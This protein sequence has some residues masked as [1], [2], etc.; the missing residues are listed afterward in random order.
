MDS[1]TRSLLAGH[2]EALAW[3]ATQR[4]EK[5]VVACIGFHRVMR[6]ARVV[7]G[8][9]AVCD[10]Y[11]PVLLGISE[12]GSYHC[13]ADGEV[14]GVSCPAI[15]PLL[16]SLAVAVPDQLAATLELQAVLLW[17]IV[18]ALQPAILHAHDIMGLRT[19][20]LLKRW[21]EAEGRQVP[22]VYDSHE[23]V[24]GLAPSRRSRTMGELQD[25]CIHAADALI[26]VGQSILTSIRSDYGFEKPG[27]IVF[28]CPPKASN[29]PAEE[30][31]L[32]SRLGLTPDTPLGVWT[33]SVTHARGPQAF[34][35]SLQR[36]TSVHLAFLTP[37]FTPFFGD[38]LDLARR[39]GCEERIHTVPLVHYSVVPNAIKGADF[40]GIGFIPNIANHEYAM[41][42]KFFEYLQAEIP[43][44]VTNVL[45]MGSFVARHGVGEVYEAD[46]AVSCAVA[47]QRVLDNGIERYAKRLRALVGTY[48]WEYQASQIEEIYSAVRTSET[49]AVGDGVEEGLYFDWVA[50][51]AWR[52][53]LEQS[54]K[55]EN[56]SEVH[57]DEALSAA[58]LWKAGEPAIMLVENPR[59]VVG[60]I[61]E[62]A[63]FHERGGVEGVK[64]TIDN[65][66][67]ACAE[68]AL[69][70][71][72]TD[73]PGLMDWDLPIDVN[74]ALVEALLR[75]SRTASDP[76]ISDITYEF[77]LRMTRRVED[78]GLV[79][80]SKAEA[81]M[82]KSRWGVPADFGLQGRAFR[83]LARFV[84]QNQSQQL[85]SAMDALAL[86][87]CNHVNAWRLAPEYEYRSFGLIVPLKSSAVGR[88]LE[89]SDFQFALTGDLVRNYA[90]TPNKGLVS[91]RI[92]SRNTDAPLLRMEVVSALHDRAANE[93]AP[94]VRVHI[95][96]GWQPDVG[97]I[98]TIVRDMSGEI[99][100]R[101]AAIL[102]TDMGGL[103]LTPDLKATWWSTRRSKPEA[104]QEAIISAIA[105]AEAIFGATRRSEAYNLLRSLWLLACELLG[106]ERS[107]EEK[108][109]WKLSSISGPLTLVKIQ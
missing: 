85:H 84:S 54:D 19:G 25:R 57:S 1:E 60:L 6:D 59:N 46:S 86:A 42:N 16:R 40:G 9:K 39:A 78:G 68:H 96:E 87:V 21:F 69:A 24:R 90:V 91:A 50:K 15:A 64:Q 103:T 38:L 94:Q 55:R 17:P 100:R 108:V 72:K 79:A 41:P 34:I 63:A 13:S 58:P 44:I 29:Q 80:G 102:T 71:K 107:V 81:V 49:V 62:I 66:L 67:D 75:L 109:G 47:I 37:R 14:L 97:R 26:T 10:V 43:V 53:D 28:N 33:G 12:S 51:P 61:R 70:M 48:C 30:R 77:A 65:L 36:L 73:G 2:S 92:D 82:L 101:R 7:K 89:L 8:A 88:S 95:P 104:A 105:L 74:V 31:S 99:Q 106:A 56:S 32:K 11:Q 83:S 20:A 76:R 4:R 3:I 45:D 18:R 27:R 98:A 23:Y 35:S 5:P 52:E 22:L 93:A